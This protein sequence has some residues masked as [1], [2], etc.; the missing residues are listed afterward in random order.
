MS[1]GQLIPYVNDGAVATAVGV[2]RHAITATDT[3]YT[4]Q[5][6]VNARI[7]TISST[8]NPYLCQK[9]KG[10]KTKGQIKSKQVRNT[11]F[12]YYI[13]FVTPQCNFTLKTV[14]TMKETP[15]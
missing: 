12:K 11:K 15:L 3:E 1:S 13:L 8:I 9:I 2:I 14:Y 4:T 6:N 7:I 5:S 10:Q